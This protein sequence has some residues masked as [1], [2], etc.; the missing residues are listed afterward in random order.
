M[1]LSDNLRSAR[2]ISKF[3][4]FGII[5]AKIVHSAAAINATTITGFRLT[6]SEIW[7]VKRRTIAK[8]MVEKDKMRLLW[9]ALIEKAFDRAGIMG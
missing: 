7:S 1:P 8:V 5:D 6:A 9:A 4:Q 2:I 3:C